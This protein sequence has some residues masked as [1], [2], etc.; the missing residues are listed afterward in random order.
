MVGR[1]KSGGYPAV[2]AGS[3]EETLPTSCQ[4]RPSSEVEIVNCRIR[5]GLHRRNHKQLYPIDFR[6]ALTTG[7]LNVNLRGPA[8]HFQ[9]CSLGCGRERPHALSS[10]ADPGFAGQRQRPTGED[11]WP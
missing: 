8:H 2:D 9:S 4:V 1:A 11:E 7:D 10:A 3:G 5:G 6:H